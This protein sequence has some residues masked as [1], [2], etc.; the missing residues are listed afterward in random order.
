MADC[1]MSYDRRRNVDAYAPG[2]ED[3]EYDLARQRRDDDE[4]ETDHAH[5]RIP[6]APRS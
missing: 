4:K 6:L 3:Y 2:N 1:G 5:H